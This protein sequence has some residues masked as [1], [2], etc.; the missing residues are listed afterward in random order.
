M[1]YERC[2]S[3]KLAASFVL[4]SIQYFHRSCASSSSSF[5]LSTTIASSI[6]GC[7]QLQQIFNSST[8]TYMRH[9]L[10]NSKPFGDILLSISK[11][12]EEEEAEGKDF[13]VHRITLIK[14]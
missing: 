3:D 10:T 14:F 9:S 11:R 4:N 6:I 5:K 13:A 1:V 7:C 2:L 12:E 8:A